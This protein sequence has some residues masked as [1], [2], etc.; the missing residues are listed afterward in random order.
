MDIKKEAGEKRL[1]RLG[2]LLGSFWIINTALH[3]Y[4]GDAIA[5]FWFCNI[6]IAVLAFACFEKSTTAAYSTIAIA[7]IT[8][9]FWIIDWIFFILFGFGPLNLFQFYANVPI[10]IKIVSFAE[11][12]AT[13]PLSIILLYNLAPKKPSKKSYGFLALAT[14]S[15]IIFSKYIP[16]SEN[17]NCASYPCFQKVL[18]WGAQPAYTLEWAL[19]IILLGVIAMRYIV[20]PAHNWLIKKRQAYNLRYFYRDAQQD[21][22]NSASI[23][24]HIDSRHYSL[25]KQS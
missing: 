19:S 6:A 16:S 21:R 24:S 13:I 20:Y 8:Q 23:H 15:L 9:P 3:I 1:K 2:V 5:V 25:D 17:I 10:A 14:L 12:I 4:Y 11:H 7:L 22:R 18:A